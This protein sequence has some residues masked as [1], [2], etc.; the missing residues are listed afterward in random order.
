MS[1]AR[2]ITTSR[3]TGWAAALTL[4][5]GAPLAAGQIAPP[6]G[7]KPPETPAWTPPPP[8]P[9]PAPARQPLPDLPYESLVERT[10]DGRLV[11][12]DMPADWAA[13]ERNPMVDESTRERVA[14]AL[15][16][17]KREYEQRVIDNL[18]LLKQVDEGILDKLDL[19]D[20]QV[21]GQVLAVIEPLRTQG[22]TVWRALMQE[23]RISDQQEE[24]NR[25]I[26]L[27]Y[28]K[29]LEAE[30]TKDAG[31]DLKVI[32]RSAFMSGMAETM[33]AR[34]RLYLEA[35]ANIDR[36]LQGVTL[37]ADASARVQAVKTADDDNARF[38]AV[39]ALMR[40]LSIEDQKKVLEAT[41]AAR[42]AQ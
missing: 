20:R 15:A 28:T 24:F 25:K 30:I 26:A 19:N 32:F 6:P 17:R 31:Q 42:P 12:L 5:L 39:S 35:G 14:D 18:D 13:W 23:G 40:S 8:P 21:L 10:D 37:P 16:S 7:P 3:A 11:R 36:V 41:V 1:A 33:W 27:E 34:R 29:A 38:E 2:N 4:L 22:G 9:P